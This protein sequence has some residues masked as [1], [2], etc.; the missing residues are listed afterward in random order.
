MRR[1]L[2]SLATRAD[3]WPVRTRAG[4]V[5]IFLGALLLLGLAVHI[6]SPYVRAVAL[7]SDVIVLDSSIRPLTW[8]SGEP[9]REWLVWAEDGEGQLTLPAGSRP[10]PA[11]VLMLGARPA[12]VDDPR[13]ARITESLA[14]SGYAVLLPRSQPLVDGVV[15]PIEVERL[16]DAVLAVANH[17]R[18]EGDTVT[19]VGLSVGGSLSLVAATDPRIRERLTAVFAFGPYYNGLDLIAQ[20]AAGAVPTAEGEER[21][22][23]L[24][25]TT[26]WVLL[27]SL[28]AVPPDK[29]L[30]ATEAIEMLIDAVE[31]TA[32]LTLAEAQAATSRMS[33][34]QQQWLADISPDGRLHGISA[35][36]YLLHDYGDD[37]IPVEESDRIASERAP[38]LDRRTDL[39]EHVTPDPSNLGILLRDGV[40]M[41]D[42]FARIIA[43]AR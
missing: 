33:A 43:H 1:R 10:A 39:F 11:M 15:A 37:L 13:V 14:R 41:V 30:A 18:T 26:R 36:W 32:P 12:G 3:R 42:L 28:R 31:G 6:T 17:P 21:P 20:A 24:N 16:V 19:L 2:R 23:T 8:F 27:A 35:P 29:D 4:A 40:R 25:S 38:T 34:Q 9:T 22:W 7:F 5:G